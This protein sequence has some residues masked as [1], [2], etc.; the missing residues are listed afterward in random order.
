MAKKQDRLALNLI[1]AS[2]LAFNEGDMK[3]GHRYMAYA[4]EAPDYR[5][6][7][8][9][10]DEAAS[11]EGDDEDDFDA[12]NDSADDADEVS[13]DTGAEE[14]SFT[15]MRK[16]ARRALAEMEGEA[17]EEDVEEEDPEA[18]DEADEAEP[19]ASGDV[20]ADESDNAET[21][22]LKRARHNLR[23][24]AGLETAEEDPDVKGADGDSDDDL[25]DEDGE[26]LSNIL[27]RSMK[28]GAKAAKAGAKK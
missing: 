15:K 27:R 23:L 24:L 12:D 14:A 17:P 9:A 16:Q 11:D 3:K 8:A 5:E 19:K 26:E 1:L 21:S 28:R 6:T 7:I 13:D 18:G 22:R 20:D 25:S 10:L 2:V 4:L